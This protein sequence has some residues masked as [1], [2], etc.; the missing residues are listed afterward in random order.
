[1]APWGSRAALTRSAIAQSARGSPQTRR[2]SFHSVGQRDRIRLPPSRAARCRSCSIDL[3]GRRLQVQSPSAW[4]RTIPLPACAWTDHRSGSSPSTND[5][6]DDGRRF[7]TKL[8]GP[9]SAA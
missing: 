7:A 3:R 1:M 5:A 9:S 6:T 4:A 2:R 8:T